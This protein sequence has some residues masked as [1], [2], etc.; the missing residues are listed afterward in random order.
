MMVREFAQTV[1][2]EWAENDV[3][4]RARALG[5]H[6][7]ITLAS[8]IE[9]EAKLPEDRPLVASVFYNRL[10]LNMPLQSC[11]TVQFALGSWK[12]RLSLDDL[13]IDSPYNTYIISDSPPGPYTH[14]PGCPQCVQHSNPLIQI[15]FSLPRIKKAGTFSAR[16]SKSTKK[17]SHKYRYATRPS[18]FEEGTVVN[19]CDSG[20]L[21]LCHNVASL[22]R[23]VQEVLY[24]VLL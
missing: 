18:E 19:Y 16:R 3:D 8:I 20:G 21:S 11:A 1:L 10:N 23:L 24:T 15:I 12:M 2:P 9:K 22:A 4:E 13:K 17:L 7:V 14:V 5:L 6:G